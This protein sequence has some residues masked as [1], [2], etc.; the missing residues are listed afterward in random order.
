[1]KQ[2]IDNYFTDHY[3]TC[4]A[5]LCNSKVQ[6]TEEKTAEVW[7]DLQDVP[8]YISAKGRGN[9][10]FRNPQGHDISVL[11]YD[12]YITKLPGKFGTGRQRCDFI[13][14]DKVSKIIVLD[15][16]TSSDNHKNIIKPIK[17]RKNGDIKYQ[18]GK[19]E[20]AREQLF[21]TLQTLCEVKEINCSLQKY[22][23]KIC[24]C[25]CK[26]CSSKV[27]PIDRTLAAFNRGVKMTD[28]MKK[29][30]QEIEA[31]G[32]EYRLLIHPNAFALS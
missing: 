14:E 15:E 13:I 10:S 20:K 11:G 18:G 7:F 29:S 22:D 16:M 31:F 24:L 23:K 28:G 6:I 9:A 27:K 1:M 25:S 30:N 3:A 21:A 5:A 2:L 26:L 19:L 4:F 8:P 17:K 32:F 12:D